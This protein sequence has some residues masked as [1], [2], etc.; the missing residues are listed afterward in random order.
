MGADQ[1]KKQAEEE[2]LKKEKLEKE[3]N[4]KKGKLGKLFQKIPGDLSD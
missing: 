4:S 1:L 3:A 2:R